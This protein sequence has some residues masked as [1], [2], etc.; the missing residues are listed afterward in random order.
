MTQADVPMVS[1]IAPCRNEAAFVAAA[2]QTILDNDYPADSLELL[3][4]DGMSTDGTRE[5]VAGIAERDNRVRL[6]DNPHK[7]VS[8]AMN[9]GI[10]KSRGEYIIRIDCHSSFAPDYVPKC[11]E[12]LQRTGADDV[13]GYMTTLPGADTAVAKA[14]ANA[15]SS[16]FGVGNSAFR[17]SGPE[18]E[19]DTVPFGTYR[20]EIFDKIGLYD[21]RLLRNQDIELNWR[22]RK[23]GGRIIISPEIKLSYYNRDT[24]RGLAQQ[25]FNNGFWNPYTIWL[26]GG[27]L[28]FRHFVPMFF[29]SGLIVFT[30]GAF[31]AQPV[32]WMLLGYILLY[33]SVASLVSIK[34]ALLDTRRE[35]KIAPALLTLWSFV[36]L[37]TAYGLGSL[38]SIITI[39]F[40]Q[41]IKFKH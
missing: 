31:F 2:I 41:V 38:W 13:G 3:V 32:K 33:L 36:V 40:R 29:V 27:G 1:V 10:K 25:S 35:S 28:S 19:V 22:I 4:V 11:V 37:H 17:L 6:L 12:V 24:Y 26:I 23:A 16:K 20:R 8:S 7:F 34:S 14:I 5:I 18:Q 9:I 39:P 15:T 21:E 30:T